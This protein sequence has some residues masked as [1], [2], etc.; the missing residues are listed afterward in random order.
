SHSTTGALASGDAISPAGTNP[1]LSRLQLSFP[2]DSSSPSQAH[3]GSAPEA[4]GDSGACHHAVCPF[5][6]TTRPRGLPGIGDCVTPVTESTNSQRTPSESPELNFSKS[7][8]TISSP[9]FSSNWIAPDA[10]TPA[11]AIVCD[12]KAVPTAIESDQLPCERA[13]P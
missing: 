12:R 11:T 6:S 2:P 9:L 10:D 8:A 4:T 7:P 13:C 3:S 5:T 1:R